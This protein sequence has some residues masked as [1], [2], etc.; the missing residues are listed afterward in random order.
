MVDH[1]HSD[2]RGQ[3]AN[4]ICPWFRRHHPPGAIDLSS[5]FVEARASQDGN[6]LEHLPDV[7][8][9]ADA[10]MTSTNDDWMYVPAL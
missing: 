8:L 1:E 10:G 7:G 3:A 6:D 2:R 5:Q 9:D 4:A